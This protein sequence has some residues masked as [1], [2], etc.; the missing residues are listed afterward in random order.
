MTVIAPGNHINFG[1]PSNRQGTIIGP[2]NVINMLGYVDIPDTDTAGPLPWIIEDPSRFREPIKGISLPNPHRLLAVGLKIPDTNLMGKAANLIGTDTATFRNGSG[3]ADATGAIVTFAG[4]TQGAREVMVV[5]P[6]PAAV[7]AAPT[8]Q[9]FS[10]A[11]IRSSL[12]TMRLY[13]Y[14]QYAVPMLFPNIEE[15]VS[16]NAPQIV[17]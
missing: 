7:A 17:N 12:G 3:A 6:Y 8:Y 1:S 10:S 16:H 15:V 13:G 5:T 11:P 2:L 14:L 9:L 4:T